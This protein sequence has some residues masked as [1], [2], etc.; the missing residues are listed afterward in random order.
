ME[1]QINIKMTN[2]V[3]MQRKTRL[4]TGVFNRLVWKCRHADV[5]LLKVC[6]SLNRL[7]EQCNKLNDTELLLPE[8]AQNTGGGKGETIWLG[9]GYN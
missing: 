9:G 8:C 4:I 3:Q 1:N 7:E 5:C 6:K 2:A